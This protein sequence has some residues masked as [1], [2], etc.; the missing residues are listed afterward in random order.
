[1]LLRIAGHLY[2]LG[3]CLERAENT[4]RSL[5]AFCGASFLRRGAPSTEPGWE[6]LLMMIGRRGDFLTRYDAFSAANVLRFMLFDLENPVSLLSSVRAARENGRSACGTLFPETWE[7]LNTLWIDLKEVD[8]DR[9]SP[10]RV[11]PFIDRIKEGADLFHGTVLRALPH[12]VP[13][14]MIGLGAAIERADHTARVLIAGAP[15]LLEKSRGEAGYYA[16]IKLLRSVGAAAIYRKRHRDPVA[17]E[18][19]VEFLI[20]DDRS[21]SSL[22]ACLDRINELLEPLSRGIGREALRLSSD[23]HFLLHNDQAGVILRNA[24]PEYLVDF[25]SALCGL[26][27]E[28]GKQLQGERCA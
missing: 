10:D 19:V 4:A 23:L 21:P 3:R 12:D 26:D 6:G 28:I 22:H 15:S 24:L 27:L 14:R 9:L 7:A 16:S 2:W 1:M 20:L 8:P 5:E 13:S 18:K 25:T 11:G 17:P